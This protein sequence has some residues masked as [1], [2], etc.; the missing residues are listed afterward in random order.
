MAAPYNP[1]V[2][3]EDQ[4]IYIALSDSANPGR[5]KANPTIAA[6]D[7]QIGLDDGAMGNPSTGT[8]TVSPAGSIWVKIIVT[9]AETNGNVFKLQCIDQ[10]SPPEWDDLAI[11]IPTTAP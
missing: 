7:I 2:K 6:G 8:P 10:T 9:A 3:N 5:F 4:I 11:P 1:P